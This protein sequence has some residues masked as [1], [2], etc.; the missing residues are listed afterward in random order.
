M[1]VPTLFGT[2]LALVIIFGIYLLM[3]PENLHLEYRCVKGH[4]WDSWM[5]NYHTCPTCGKE[6]EM[7][8]RVDK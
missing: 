6:A 7:V 8:R 5:Y 3:K 1:L 2:L 4:I